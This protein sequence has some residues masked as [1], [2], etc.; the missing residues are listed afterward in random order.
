[1]RTVWVPRGRPP[2]DGPGG[3]GNDDNDAAD[4]ADV[5]L[6]AQYAMKYPVNACA[7]DDALGPEDV[8]QIRTHRRLVWL[9]TAARPPDDPDAVVAASEDPDAPVTG[10]E[11]RLPDDADAVVL[12]WRPLRYVCNAT[13]ARVLADRLVPVEQSLPRSLRTLTCTGLLR[14]RLPPDDAPGGATRNLKALFPDVRLSTAAVCVAAAVLLVVVC[15]A[16]PAVRTSGATGKR[17]N[18]RHRHHHQH[19]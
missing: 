2:D 19:V 7:P 13:A 3:N 15:V 14:A 5:S 16:A 12:G 18:A 17:E 4:W 8:R 10:A 9:P 1:M 6:F 11:A